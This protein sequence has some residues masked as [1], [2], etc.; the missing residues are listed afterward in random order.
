MKRIETINNVIKLLIVGVIITGP[1]S[2]SAMRPVAQF[3]SDVMDYRPVD[4]NGTTNH[5]YSQDDAK[6]AVMNSYAAQAWNKGSV[7][8]GI[9]IGEAGVDLISMLTGEDLSQVQNIMQATNKDLISDNHANSGSSQLVGAAFYGGGHVA[10][11]FEDKNKDE[12]NKAFER[13]HEKERENDKYWDCR[14]QIDEVTGR[15]IDVKKKYGMGRVMQCIQERDNAERR[16]ILVEALAECNSSYSI[17]EIDEFLNSD[18][19]NV[20]NKGN[21]IIREAMKCYYSHHKETSDEKEDNTSNNNT[22]ASQNHNSISTQSKTNDNNF[23]DT[24]GQKKIQN[25]P[26]RQD[27]SSINVSD[28][29]DKYLLEQTTINKYE[30]N[31]FLLSD[32]NK[33][34][35]NKVAEILRK[36]NSIMIQLV[37]HTCNI[38][39]DD[40]NYNLGL[41]RATEAKKYLIEKG[42]DS[43]RISVQSAG[44]HKPITSNITPLDRSLNRRVEVKVVQ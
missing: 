37:G 8:R 13:A 5:Q 29:S 4:N 25:R 20:R 11:Y 33:D 19:L 3:I 44:K 26:D 23:A 40:V 39:N 36:N 6:D 28:P 30:L 18:D 9:L 16:S 34:A 35:L 38:G 10:G 15:Y 27:N 21:T 14:Y 31:S 43:N 7:S 1:I 17:E 32:V 2:L 22:I 42:V 41:L 12:D 24:A